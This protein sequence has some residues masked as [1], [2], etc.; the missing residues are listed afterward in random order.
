MRLDGEADLAR[1]C[2]AVRIV[3]DSGV[4]FDAQYYAFQR[5]GIPHVKRSFAAELHGGLNGNHALEL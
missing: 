5:V 2:L 4:R 3:L 1:T